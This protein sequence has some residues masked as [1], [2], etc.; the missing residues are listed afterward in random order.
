MGRRGWIGMTLA[1]G[2]WR[3]RTL[4]PGT[5]R[6]AGGDARRRRAG[7]AALDRRPAIRTVD[8]ARRHR[9]A[10]ENPAGD[11]GRRNLCLHRH[12]RARCRAPTSPRCAPGRRRFRAAIWST[13]PRCGPAFAHLSQYMI[14]FCRTGRRSEDRH[15]G[16]SQFLVD[17]RNTPGITI[18]PILALTGEHHFN[19]VV[20]QDAFL[21]ESGAARQ[22]RRRLASGDQRAGVR[23]QRAGTIPVVV[24]AAYRT[25]AR[26][27][28][29]SVRRGGGGD[30]PA[31][32]TYHDIAAAVAFGRRHVAGRARTRRCRPRWSRILAR[33]GTGNPRD[34]AHA[35]SPPSRT[36]VQPRR[37]PRR[38]R[39]PCC[40]RRRSRCAAARAKSCVGSSHAG[41]GLTSTGILSPR[42]PFV[43]ALGCELAFPVLSRT[44]GS[45]P[46]CQRVADRSRGSPMSVPVDDRGRAAALAG[47]LMCLSEK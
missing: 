44:S 38:W 18:R 25:A 15:G 39:T 30:R 21:P 13:A 5:L 34:R 29:R 4:G 46:L 31:D 26:S 14:L 24:L 9:G 47:C 19:E 33:A 22:R 40:M 1:E 7:R 45:A 23:T 16:L 37:S 27:G 20:F 35:W 10:A 32:V 2:A 17:L 6:G 42:L 43:L 3:A 36:A 28:P 8:P 12:E 41:W 11:R